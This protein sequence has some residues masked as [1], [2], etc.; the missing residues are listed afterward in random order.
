M[1]FKTHV[2]TVMVY[3][4]GADSRKVIFNIQMLLTT[5]FVATFTNWP[6]ESEGESLY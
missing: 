2:L 1:R 5:L 4:A 6:K 3:F